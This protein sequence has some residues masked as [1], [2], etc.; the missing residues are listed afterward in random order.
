M[1][2][3]L[4]ACLLFAQQGAYAAL[5]VGVAS[6]TGNHTVAVTCTQGDVT[7][8]LTHAKALRV[9]HHEAVEKWL[10]LMASDRSDRD[11]LA[12]A[13]VIPAMMEPEWV[14]NFAQAH[15]GQWMEMRPAPWEV[16]DWGEDVLRWTGWR[17]GA[18]AIDERLDAPSVQVVS[19]V[20]RLL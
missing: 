7:V 4:L 19:G 15:D 14:F 2:V 12:H 18:E 5:A 1:V 11:H 16:M 6:L 9:H 17:V 8:R 10:L 3:A 13:Q 20:Q